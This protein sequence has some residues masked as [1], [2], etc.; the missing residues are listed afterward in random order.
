VSGVLRSMTG[1]GSAAAEDERMKASVT[2]RSL[3]HRYLDVSVHLSRRVSAIEADVRRAVQARLQRG[4]VEVAV[5]ASLR[6]QDGEVVPN[7]PLIAGLVRAL[8][9]VKAEHALAGDVQ[10]ADVVRFPGAFESQEAGGS[11]QDAE[12]DELLALLATA[13]DGLDQ[14][15]VAEGA[16]LREAL[17]GAVQAVEDAT[18]RIERLL[19]QE[20]GPRL[21]ALQAKARTLLQELGVEEQRLYQ[22]LARLVDRGDVAEELQRLRSHAGQAR[23][24]V[25][26]AGPCGK[27]L[28]FLAQELGREANTIGSKSDSA[29]LAQEVV[30]LKGEIERFREQVQNVE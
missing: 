18:A 27:R 30:D 28:D 21:L 29:A 5:Q 17:L 7:R 10:V 24:I 14:M 3:N 15:R 16:R 13:L 6:G 25:E 26:Q 4:R 23:A 1:F 19:E 22:E 11:L 2:V 9:E 8:R 12:R 20:R